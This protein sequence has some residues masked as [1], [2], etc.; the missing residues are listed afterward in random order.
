MKY[1]RNF[2]TDRPWSQHQYRDGRE[3]MN[4]LRDLYA[5]GSLNDVQALYWGAERPAEEL[6]DLNDDPHEISTLVDD[7]IYRETL[8]KLRKQMDDWVRDSDDQGQYPESAESLAAVYKQWRGNCVNPEYTREIKA[9]A[10][11]SR[12]AKRQNQLNYSPHPDQG[13]WKIISVSSEAKQYQALA[14]NLLDGDPDNMWHTQWEPEADQHPHTLIIDLAKE[15]S[16]SGL[17]ILPRQFGSLNGSISEY[18][19]QLSKDLEHWDLGAQ[20]KLDYPGGFPKGAREKSIQFERA[21]RARYVKLVA[22]TETGGGPWASA[23]EI[24]VIFDATEDSAE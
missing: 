18:K 2:M 24:N 11:A 23:A 9:A 4:V 5:K 7:P 22:L 6:F 16:V 19:V 8:H 12:L 13:D 15:R 17:R 10:D 20:G 14:E 3:Y 21:Y 1:I